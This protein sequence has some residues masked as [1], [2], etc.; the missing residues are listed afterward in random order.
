MDSLTIGIIS[1][2]CVITGLLIGLYLGKTLPVSHLT[3]SSKDTIKMA[4]GMIATLSALVLGLLVASAKNSFDTFDSAY[5]EI[6]AKVIV[7]DQLLTQ[8]GPDS[9]AARDELRN[10]VNGEIA[11]IWPEL[12][13]GK[14]TSTA[15]EKSGDLEPLQEKLNELNPTTENER[16]VLPEARALA[17]D[18]EQ[19]RWNLIERAQTS[20]PTALYVV[21]LSWLTMLFISIGLFAPR[22][23]TVLTGLLLCSLSFSMA[24][25]LFDEM[26]SPLDGVIKVSSGP[27]L[28]ALDHLKPSDNK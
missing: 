2:C 8:Y 11:R 14:P 13:V 10:A 7:L 5:T 25:Y 21:L 12:N 23:F 9:A 18:L 26:A 16:T 22:N 20:V 1:A 4:S 28:K 24:I 17:A 19:S 15:L 6:G 3:D 27:M